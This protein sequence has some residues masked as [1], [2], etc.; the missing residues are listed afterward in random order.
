MRCLALATEAK[1]RKLGVLFFAR[2]L[3][4]TLKEKIEVAGVQLI[5]LIGSQSSSDQV[6]KHSAWL[7]V[8]ELEDAAESLACIKSFSE[9]EGAPVAI[10]VDHYALG[11]PWHER[12]R[13]VAPVVAIDELGDRPLAPDWLV[14]QTEGKT[15]NDY[16]GLVADHTHLLLGGKFALLR[17]E[18]A[19]Q[20]KFTGSTRLPISTPLQV[21]VTMGGV[22][23]DNA[24]SAVISA[25]QIASSRIPLEATLV[26]GG[27]NPNRDELAARAAACD[28]SLAVKVDVEN[29]AELMATHD[30][31]I[32]AA[33]TTTWECCAMGMPS[34]NLILA[35]NQQ[36]VC[37]WLAA[38]GASIN[39]GW[40]KDLDPQLMADAIVSMSCDPERY[41]AMVQAAFAVTD[42]YGCKRLLDAALEKSATD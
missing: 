16:A 22:D 9:A 26:I 8:S 38:T 3:D 32:G 15:S 6:Y 19:E 10:V 29:M 37:K 18:F 25:L 17:P 12:L 20:V 39:L 27:A 36:P 4:E 11:Q 2:S 7:S 24:S 42:G 28:F 14:D 31:A 1:K 41:A 13:S 35:E 21:L 40:A 30:L 5:E 34:L 23:A 33:G